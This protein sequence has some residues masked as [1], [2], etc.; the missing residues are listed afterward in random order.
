MDGLQTLMILRQKV[1][2]IGNDIGNKENLIIEESLKEEPQIKSNA[3]NWLCFVI[4]D[5]NNIK[6]AIVLNEILG[7]P[8]GLRPYG[9]GEKF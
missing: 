6:K 8:R 3:G 9:G 5:K 2:G 1:N 7:E 4:T